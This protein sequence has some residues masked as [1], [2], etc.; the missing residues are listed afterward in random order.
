ME[1]F[2]GKLREKADCPW[3]YATFMNC[4]LYDEDIG[5]YMSNEDKL[6]KQGDFYTSNHVHPVFGETFGRFF[7]DIFHKEA[8]LPMVIEWGA[9]DG[10]F[11]FSI[12]RYFYEYEPFIYDQMN[13]IIIEA[14]S[15]HR[16]I[17]EEKL[18]DY[19]SKVHL[20]ES[21][22][23]VKREFP[24]G[25]GILF[26]NEFIDAFPIHV[27]QKKDGTL[28]ECM[29]Q[30][31]DNGSLEE[32]AVKCSNVSLDEWLS[33]Y[34][35]TDLP[36]GHRIEICLN[37]KRWLIDISR[38]IRKGALITVDYG[39]TNEEWTEPE[40]REG[41]LRGYYHHEMV[42]DPL[43]HIGKMDLTFHV[44][45]DA[46]N[47]IAEEL[48]WLKLYHD[49]QD[50]FLKHAGIFRF[51]SHNTSMNLTP[52]S[53]DYKRN[54]AIQSFV[55]PGGISSSFQVN[56][57]TKQLHQTKQYLLFTEDPYKI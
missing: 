12:L 52:F 17:L 19:T 51:L 23:D 53:E 32:I 34:G 18:K 49:T 46:F 8:I 41:S 55:H 43:K 44:Q 39:Y 1:K 56:I 29:V 33:H 57:Q 5:Y 37:M 2:V 27:V 6:G 25:E 9:G 47:M 15:F 50:R 10:R 22:E 7:A 14:S 40:H 38:W 3:S 54:R 30:N 4:A 36:D 16:S 21:F 24:N 13:Y 11:A 31:N 48:G 28:F 45:W 26:S 42:A 20:F 35:P